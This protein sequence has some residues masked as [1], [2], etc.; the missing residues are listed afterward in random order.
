M[1]SQVQK[2]KCIGFENNGVSVIR[3]A[4]AIYGPW[5]SMLDGEADVRIALLREVLEQISNLIFDITGHHALQWNQTLLF[6]SSSDCRK[7]YI[8]IEVFH[9]R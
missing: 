1:K 9:I 8:Q 7:Q 5:K 4:H 2:I 6:K 3:I